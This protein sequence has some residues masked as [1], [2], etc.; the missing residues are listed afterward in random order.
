M[1]QRTRLANFSVISMPFK[2][3]RCWWI[4]FIWI[5]VPPG[6]CYITINPMN[7]TMCWNSSANFSCA[8]NESSQIYWEI[9]GRDVVA[10][11]VLGPMT[12]FMSGAQSILTVPGSYELDGV[13]V[14]CYYIT[15]STLYSIPAFLR[16]QGL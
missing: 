14:T 5:L 15:P 10:Y 16:V 6:S 2:R 7:V 8:T 3:L 9:N 12:T 11:N 1:K 13:Y 4:C